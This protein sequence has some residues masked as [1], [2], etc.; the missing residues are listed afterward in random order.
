MP[1][2]ERAIR[3][4]ILKTTINGCKFIPTPPGTEDEAERCALR[5]SK[6]RKIPLITSIAQGGIEITRTLGEEMRS[7]Y[8]EIDNLQVGQFY[9]FP[10]PPS[11]HG[12]VRAAASARNKT[13][14]VRYACSRD[15]DQ[16]R[17]TRL[18]MTAEEV[19]TCGKIPEVQRKNRWSRLNELD[20]APLL[21]FEVSH[22][23]D[24]RAL[25]VAAYQKGRTMG[26]KIRC[27]LQDNGTMAVYR[28]DPGA[29][30][31]PPNAQQAAE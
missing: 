21:I 1:I 29:P 3:A 2:D 20:S 17:V 8:P 10:L 26:W 28:T 30:H 18:P 16:I 9:V 22:F 11:M 12:R 25:R 13:G 24:E 7:I 31:A 15:V 23:T 19:E 14:K 6:A 27:R 5:F 4:S